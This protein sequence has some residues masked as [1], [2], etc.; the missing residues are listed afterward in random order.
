MQEDM[1]ELKDPIVK[2]YADNLKEKIYDAGGID[3]AKGGFACYVRDFIAS[4]VAEAE[5]RGY[6]KIK[7]EL[8]KDNAKAKAKAATQP[9]DSV[10]TKT[11][12]RTADDIQNASK[13]DWLKFVLN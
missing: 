2:K 4:A 9:G 10:Q 11:S 8:E 1:L 13:E 12:I 7:N 3:L 6:Q 5:I